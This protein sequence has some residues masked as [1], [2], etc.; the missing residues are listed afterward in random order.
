MLIVYTTAGAMLDIPLERVK[1]VFN[2]NT[3]ASLSIA[4]AVVPHMASRKTGLIVNIGSIAG[5]T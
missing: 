1:D 5:M 3:F 2:T 4:K